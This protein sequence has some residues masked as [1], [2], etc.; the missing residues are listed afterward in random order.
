MIRETVIFSLVILLVLIQHSFLT[1]LEIGWMIMPNLVFLF[2]FLLPFFTPSC[3]F[4]AFSAGFLMDLFFAPFFGFYIL[5][6]LTIILIVKKSFRFFRKNDFFY[7][8]GM[9]LFS[10]VCYYLLEG[11]SLAFIRRYSFN[12]EKIIGESIISFLLITVIFFIFKRLN[13]LD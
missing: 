2:I 3:L 7:F 11:L 1:S 4:F 12:F 10:L 6:F 5:I 13:Y 9:F 8:S